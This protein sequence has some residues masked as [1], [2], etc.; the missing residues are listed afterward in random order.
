MISVERDLAASNTW[1]HEYKVLGFCIMCMKFPM[2]KS[3]FVC[4]F[5]R[6]CVAIH[7]LMMEMDHLKIRDFLHLQKLFGLEVCYDVIRSD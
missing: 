7:A 5:T 2:K 3:N 6:I 1:L 4:F